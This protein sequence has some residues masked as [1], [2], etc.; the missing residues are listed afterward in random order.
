VIV[1]ASD[2]F[3]FTDLRAIQAQLTHDPHFDLDFD[4]LTDLL[5]ARESVAATDRSIYGMRLP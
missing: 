5:A 1:T 4:L 3:T 2:R